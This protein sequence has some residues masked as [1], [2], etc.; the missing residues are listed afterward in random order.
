MLGVLP[1]LDGHTL[2]AV[3]GSCRGFR[4][5][6]LTTSRVLFRS[7]YSGVL[8][9]RFEEACVPAL[10]HAIRSPCV[11]SDKALLAWA[12]ANGLVELVRAIAGRNDAKLLS[13]RAFPPGA[14]WGCGIA[15]VVNR[16]GGS[17]AGA[18]HSAMTG[19]LGV[20]PEASL[21]SASPLDGVSR[22]WIGVEMT[23][24]PIAIAVLRGQMSA[25]VSLVR[26]GVHPATPIF[27]P[28][29]PPTRHEQKGSSRA[30]STCP[31][32]PTPPPL[33]PVDCA[34]FTALHLAA[35]AQRIEALC[36]LLFELQRHLRRHAESLTKDDD[37]SL[38][39][40]T[41]LFARSVAANASP[42]VLLPWEAPAADLTTAGMHH[43][44]SVQRQRYAA[45][46]QTLDEQLRRNPAF[47][48]SLSEPSPARTKLRTGVEQ[49]TRQ[50]PVDLAPEPEWTALPADGRSLLFAAAAA[51][52]HRACKLLLIMGAS[53]DAPTITV[54]DDGGWLPVH[55]CAAAGSTAS[56][57][58]LK[59]LHRAGADLSLP[60]QTLKTALI[61]ASDV[62]HAP[63]VQ[64]LIT[65]RVP[66]NDRSD[67]GKTAILTAAEA[68]HTSIVMDLLR[69]GADPHVP[70]KR[71]K[72][73]L[74]VAAEA[75]DADVVRTVIDLDPVRAASSITLMT[76]CGTTPLMQAERNG[77]PD[78][79]HLFRSTLKAH[80]MTTTM[81]IPPDT[82]TIIPLPSMPR[83]RPTRVLLRA[84]P[85]HPS[86]ARAL[87]DSA[88][89]LVVS[90]TLS[91]PSSARVVHPPRVSRH[92]APNTPRASRPT[93]ATPRGSRSSSRSR[94]P[95]AASSRG[96]SDM[97]TDTSSKGLSDMLTAVALAKPVEHPPPSV[98][99]NRPAT[100]S[101]QSA[102]VVLTRPSLRPQGSITVSTRRNEAGPVA[103]TIAQPSV[104]Q[105]ASPSRV[106]RVAS[107]VDPEPAV[108]GIA[109]GLPMAAE[110]KAKETARVLQRLSESL[111]ELSI[112]C[113][114]PM[115]IRAT[116]IETPLR[117]DRL[118]P[119]PQRTLSKSTIL[120]DLPPPPSA[121]P[122]LLE[123]L[124]LVREEHPP[125]LLP[126]KSTPRLHSHLLASDLPSVSL[127]C[128][129]ARSASVRSTG[130]LP[131]AQLSA[132]AFQ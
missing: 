110:S 103:A 63:T 16:G 90:V 33:G 124:A 98:E 121:G 53:T 93:S 132:V 88:P 28:R 11:A 23:S 31:S 95:S 129:P 94:P 20:R 65:A 36:V 6:V 55:V 47:A 5:A 100:L 72:T 69:A 32:L 25:L 29:P 78:V 42:T 115:G 83:S 107:F 80:K 8:Q 70:S 27:P 39:P 43:L 12:V 123:S 118:P 108:S 112:A 46:K 54:D 77:H 17:N 99:A 105:D 34:G 89:P 30:S 111:V 7:V 56:L 67:S 62:G 75:G 1:F 60:S 19:A 61:L 15:H 3:A 113:S 2:A 106:L 10:L 41:T 120:A 49:W 45:W 35:C 37:A 91:R 122:L 48:P 26:L 50:C 9:S 76:K 96:H 85:P 125:R 87:P 68:R 71:L 102:E 52:A 97:P 73:V 18:I 44:F 57:D 104:S 84:P 86:T 81:Q 51:G 114:P 119:K 24:A 92:S 13:A 40:Q 130:S 59:L 126:S 64:A 4:Q 58:C 14:S 127:R 38:L 117:R 82:S 66:L 74:H 101:L 79:L 131:P 116:P 22:Q 109:L 21:C 128:A